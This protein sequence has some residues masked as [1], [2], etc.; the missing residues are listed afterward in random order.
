MMSRRRPVDPL[1][2]LFQEVAGEVPD[3]TS[4]TRMRRISSVLNLQDN[5]ALWSIVATLEYYA[6]LYEAMPER[7]GP[8]R[9]RCVRT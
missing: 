5:D 8:V 9:C 3:E 2:R 4:L 1:I 7:V 6:R